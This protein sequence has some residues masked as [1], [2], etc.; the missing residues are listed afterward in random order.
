[1]EENEPFEDTQF[2][3]ESLDELSRQ[4]VPLS[5]NWFIG[6]INSCLHQIQFANSGKYILRSCEVPI[7][8]I[9][10]EVTITL[11]SSKISLSKSLRYVSVTLTDEWPKASLM[12]SVEIPMYLAIVAQECLIEYVVKLP[13]IPAS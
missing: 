11:T 7:N 13:S 8:H 6:F 1:M 2:P 9:S 5:E 10:Y 3:T 4:G 12:S